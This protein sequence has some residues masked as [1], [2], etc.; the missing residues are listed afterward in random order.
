MGIQTAGSYVMVVTGSG[1]TVCAAKK[2]VYRTVLD[3]KWPSNVMYRTDIGDRL[4]SDL[5][6]IQKHGFAKGMR[7]D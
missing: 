1:S 5:P 4:K 3:I 6:A 2:A 7:Y